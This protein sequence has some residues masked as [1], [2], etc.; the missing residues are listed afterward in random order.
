MDKY[1]GNY[2]WLVV[3]L[4]VSI[5]ASCIQKWPKRTTIVILTGVLILHITNPS[6]F[7][8]PPS[9]CSLRKTGTLIKS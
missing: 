3:V 6:M 7:N 5:L 2:T 1:F 4:A 8:P 9:K